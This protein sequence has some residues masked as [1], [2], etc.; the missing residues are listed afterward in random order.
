MTSTNPEL[1]RLRRELDVL[2]KIIVVNL[3][4]RFRIT[5]QIGLV[6]KQHGLPVIDESRE[7]EMTERL[8]KL[9]VEHDVDP[10]VIVS[11]FRCLI[12]Q[13][14]ERHRAI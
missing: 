4:D 7:I 9:S 5:D 2:D 8:R 10:E 11:I 3:A 12:D 6:K 13:V 1:Q 14:V